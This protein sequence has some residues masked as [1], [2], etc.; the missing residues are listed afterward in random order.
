[1]DA[2]YRLRTVRV[3][4]VREPA[5][6]RLYANGPAEAVAILRPLY[7][8]LDGDR[9]HFSILVLNAQN[10]VV[11]FKA[12]STGGTAATTVDAKNLFRDALLLGAS[13]L[14]LAH[15]HPSGDPTPSREDVRLTRQLVEGGR[16]L[17]MPIRDHIVLGDG[18][19]VSFA[20]KGLL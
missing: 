14:I 15:S 20:E 5:P 7:A 11:G 13:S 6:R 10:A 16:L 18:D 8:E 9:E 3:G 2:A 1:M 17:D 12:V 19:F 4:V